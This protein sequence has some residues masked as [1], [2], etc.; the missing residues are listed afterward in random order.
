MRP[1]RLLP[2]LLCLTTA[3]AGLAGCAAPPE[4][5]G[6][7]RVTATTFPV[8]DLARAVGGDAVALTLLCDPGADAHDFD[9]TPSD[10]AALSRAAVFVCVGGESDVW[11]DRLLAENAGGRVC[12]LIDEIS[13]LPEARVPDSAENEAIDPDADAHAHAGEADEHIWTDP[14]RAAALLSVLARVFTQADPAHGAMYAANAAAYAQRLT[15]LDADFRALIQAAPDPFLLVADRFP[16][17]Y[18]AAAYDLPYAAAFAGCDSEADPSAATVARLLRAAE[19]H[20][21][22]VIFT[23][24]LSNGRLAN[25]LAEQTGARVATLYS[26][27]SV[28]RADFDAGVTWAD[29]LARNLEALKEAWMPCG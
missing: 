9:P 17:R 25:A 29:L 14:R 24:E 6:R 15:A 1:R 28:S 20:H 3:L 22:R 13:P 23:I 11:V 18:F 7:L 21:V 16:F 4:E 10:L 27:Q 2:L 26:G 5:D 19:A 12:R 8:Y